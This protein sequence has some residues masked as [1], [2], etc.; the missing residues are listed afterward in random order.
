MKKIALIVAI[1]V[2]CGSTLGQEGSRIDSLCGKVASKKEYEA[3]VRGKDPRAMEREGYPSDPNVQYRRA[4]EIGS[5]RSAWGAIIMVKSGVEEHKPDPRRADEL[6]KDY[7]CSMELPAN[8]D[9]PAFIF[10]HLKAAA[11]RG[12]PTAMLRLSE[13][14]AKGQFEQLANED[15][16]R[17][18]KAKYEKLRAGQAS[19]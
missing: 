14:Y 7:W 2:T 4:K 11:E 9:K 16:S 3:S 17:E 19:K 12:L 5:L 13:A 18:W 10:V 1:T 15:L 6:W 8:E